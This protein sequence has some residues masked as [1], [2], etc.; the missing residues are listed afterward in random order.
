MLYFP[1]KKEYFK[2]YEQLIKK[3]DFLINTITKENTKITE[4]NIAY[5]A[6]DSAIKHL[7]V[8]TFM[9]ARYDELKN[10]IQN[11]LK[12]Y[13]NSTDK[14]NNLLNR[15]VNKTV[16]NKDNTNI[17]DNIKINIYDNLTKDFILLKYK[18]GNIIQL[19]LM[20]K[21]F[22]KGKNPRDVDGSFKT[23]ETNGVAK[24]KFQWGGNKKFIEEYKY[25]LTQAS[26]S[27]TVKLFGKENI[28]DLDDPNFD[29][30]KLP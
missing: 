11:N 16:N 1:T 30:S 15:S 3:Y 5:D 25:D 22:H 20:H 24:L 29:K 23:K 28:I 17:N 9:H 14:V 12:K 6:I 27:R 2:A 8:I 13:E 7:P 21:T 26:A 19:A 4:L 10:E 18:Y